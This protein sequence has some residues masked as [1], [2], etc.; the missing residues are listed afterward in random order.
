MELQKAIDHIRK[1]ATAHINHS[2][3]FQAGIDFS[4][5]LKSIE[6]SFNDKDSYS[7][8]ITKANISIAAAS[9]RLH[10]CKDESWKKRH[11]AML[12]GVLKLVDKR[13][14]KDEK[15]VKDKK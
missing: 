13:V 14:V 6:A 10:C 2:C 12:E 1:W 4:K 7:I 15:V 3:N 9:Y 5:N 11:D 8:G